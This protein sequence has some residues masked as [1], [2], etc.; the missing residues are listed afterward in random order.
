MSIKVIE[1]N[2]NHQRLVVI[3]VG[4]AHSYVSALSSK[5]FYKQPT[6]PCNPSMI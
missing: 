1:R 5:L 2:S 3:Y 6:Y 4:L